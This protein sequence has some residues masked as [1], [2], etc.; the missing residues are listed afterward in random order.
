[1][2]KLNTYTDG[3]PVRDPEYGFLTKEFGT[4][5]EILCD[6]SSRVISAIKTQ[7]AY[8]VYE[9]IASK[10]G[11]RYKQDLNAADA[12]KEFQKLLEEPSK[13]QRE[14]VTLVIA[15]KMPPEIGGTHVRRSSI[16]QLV[17]DF[18]LDDQY[19]ALNGL[20]SVADHGTWCTPGLVI[21]E[22]H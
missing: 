22:R 2:D 7:R 8:G 13:N 12:A 1:V 20:V 14:W 10:W 18:G 17:T 16:N 15:W 3:N 9:K 19:I 11:Q 6:L 4:Q 5:H 21:M